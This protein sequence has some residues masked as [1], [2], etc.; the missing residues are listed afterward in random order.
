MQADLLAFFECHGLSAPATFEVDRPVFGEVNLDH[1]LLHTWKRKRNNKNNPDI[2]KCSQIDYVALS[3]DI[4]TLWFQN[5]NITVQQHVSS[6][7]DWV[8]G[9]SDHWPQFQAFSVT[10]LF[11]MSAP[12]SHSHSNNS[13]SAQLHSND[14]NSKFAQVRGWEAVGDINLST[15]QRQTAFKVCTSNSLFFSISACMT[16]QLERVFLILQA[17]SGNQWASMVW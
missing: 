2:N 1:T 12:V 14:L 10:N 11:N 7:R 8:L 3:H 13:K 15:F 9:Y 6:K 17:Q 5:A 4:S 16:R